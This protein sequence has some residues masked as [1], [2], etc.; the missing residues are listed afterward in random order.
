MEP[1]VDGVSHLFNIIELARR[2]IANS[3]CKSRVKTFHH[4]VRTAKQE[5]WLLW[6]I[7]RYH[8]TEATGPQGISPPS[9]MGVSKQEAV[10]S[11]LNHVWRTKNFIHR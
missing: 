10:Y 2:W 7:A 5:R 1:E 9:G 6:R 3:G 8:G 11:I 4:C